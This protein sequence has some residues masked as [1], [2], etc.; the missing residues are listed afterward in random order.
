MEI[1]LT[2]RNGF[3][4]KEIHLFFAGK[5]N[6]SSIVRSYVTDTAEQSI[7]VDL[8]KNTAE[9]S[10]HYEL[11]IHAAGK[12]H[13]IPK[14]QEEKDAFYAENLAVSTNLLKSLDNFEQKPTCF[15]FISTVAVYGLETGVAITENAALNGSDP[16]GKSKIDSEQLITAWCKKNNVTLTIL[17][18]P[19]IVGDNPPGNLGDMIKAIEKGRF[20]LIDGG[21]AKRSMVVAQDIPMFIDKVKAIGGTY[22]LTDGYD[23]SFKELANALKKSDKGR[24]LSIPLLVAKVMAF[25]GDIIS[26]IIS[27]ELPFN[28]RKLEKMTSSLTF[29]NKKA[30]DTVDWKPTSVLDFYK[31]RD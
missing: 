9:L 25:A 22:H 21:K 4:G 31:N 15:T 13:V 14:T 2:G 5:H 20:P 23:P 19:L 6:I 17:R 28:T 11:V 29:S 18:L 8:S 1:L 7:S 27:K 10:K 24:L 16:Y 3:L 30:M 26:K 12:A